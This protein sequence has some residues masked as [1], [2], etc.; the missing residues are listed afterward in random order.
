MGSVG[1]HAGVYLTV[2]NESLGR[3]VVVLVSHDN[4]SRV[5]IADGDIDHCCPSV[6]V[7]TT[8]DDVGNCATASDDDIYDC[9][10]VSTLYTLYA[11]VMV[12]TN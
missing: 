6:A 2:G 7:W 10:V 12:S 4:V 8:I 3:V 9:V 5:T 1:C 11:A